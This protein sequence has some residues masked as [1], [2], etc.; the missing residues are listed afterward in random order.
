MIIEFNNIKKDYESLVSIN[1]EKMCLKKNDIDWKI[2]LIEKN[3][4]KSSHIKLLNFILQYNSSLEV[5]RQIDEIKMTNDNSKIIKFSSNFQRNNEFKSLINYIISLQN[6]K[7]FDIEIAKSIC[8]ASLM[9]KIYKNNISQDELINFFSN[10]DEKKN[11]MG[12]ILYIN[13][14]ND[15][16][17]KNFK[18]KINF[19][20]MNS[21][22]FVRSQNYMILI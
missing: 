10:L 18:I 7:N 5:I 9:L 15:E 16:E 17:K 19:W 8:R 4:E 21:H 3:N 20:K 6:Y 12:Q 11:R 13:N 14:E 1:E 22:I 2:P